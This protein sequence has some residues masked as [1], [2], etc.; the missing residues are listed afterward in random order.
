S[1]PAK[2][3]FNARGLANEEKFGW[4]GDSDF[5]YGVKDLGRIISN[6]RRF[7]EC[8]VVRAYEAVCRRPITIEANE[9]YVRGL[10]SHFEEAG[11]NFRKLAEMVSVTQE[12]VQ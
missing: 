6:S 2:L 3:F 1:T 4:R 7:S 8:M 12:C 11:Y 10:A 9:R 5:G